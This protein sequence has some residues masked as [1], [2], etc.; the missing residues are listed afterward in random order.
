MMNNDNNRPVEA[1]LIGAGN[2]GMIYAS[3]GIKEP[4]KLK[5][6]AV[7]EPLERRRLIA[8]ETFSLDDTQCYTNIEDILKQGKIADAIINTTM[9]QL[10]VEL[11]IP[12]FGTRL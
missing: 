10:H 5:I 6:V 2:R 1:I 7:V 8:K 3:Y 11:A 12:F 9:D 4:S